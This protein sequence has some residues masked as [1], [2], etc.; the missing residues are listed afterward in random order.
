MNTVFTLNTHIGTHID[1]T[2]H[3]YPDEA[4]VSD[5][6]I[7]RIAM[8]DAVILDVSWKAAGQGHRGRPT[9]SADPRPVLR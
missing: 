1:A 5:I 4:S 7:D 9:T 3:F 6:E 8:H 2:R